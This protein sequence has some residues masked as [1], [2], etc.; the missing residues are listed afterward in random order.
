LVVGRKGDDGTMTNRLAGESSPYLLQHQD[1]PVDW[2]PWSEEA[3]AAAKERDKPILLSIG[4]AACHWCHVMERESFEDD[5]TA[6][7]MNEHFVSIKVD[8]EERP[9]IDSIYMEAV[10]ALTGHGGWPMTMFLTTDGRPFYGGTYYPPEGRY[11]MPSF[12]TVLLAIADAWQNRR[13]EVETQSSRL[14]EHIGSATR[15]QASADPISESVLDEATATLAASFDAEHGG[16]GGAPKF[17]QAMTLDFLLRMNVRGDEKAGAI[18]RKTLDEM[19]SGGMFDQLGGGFHRYSVDRYW[20]VPHFEKMLYDNALLLRTYARAY[21]VFTEPLYRDVAERT[22][23]WMLDE[24]R[25]EGGGFYASMDA[26][27]EGVEGKYYV[28][29]LD[30]VKEVTGSDFHAAEEAWGFTAAGNFEGANIPVRAAQVDENALERARTAL[31]SRRSARVPPATDTKVLTSWSSLA[32]SALAEAGVALDRPDWIEAAA[33]AVDF[34]LVKMRP[35]GRLMRSFRRIDGDRRVGQLGVCED[36]SCLL[37][38]CLALYEATHD[39]RWFR[40][41]RWAADETLRLFLDESSGG[42]YATGTDAE[43]L[44]MRPKDLFDNAVPAS[45]SILA[46]ELQRLSR[47]SGVEDYERHGLGA[48]RPV[49]PLIAESPQ[50]FGHLLQAI[51]FYTAP[52]IEVVIVGEPGSNDTLAL[53][54]VLGSRFIPNKVLAVGDDPDEMARDIPLFE[55]RKRLDGK[56]TAFVCEH[57]VCKLPVD[58]P[59][60]LERQ[61][62][63]R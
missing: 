48:V 46:L 4:Y 32:A 3:L 47:L 1:N 14:V 11:G 17:P 34:T 57:G 50:G 40:E 43:D 5:E 28:W 39:V 49:L 19:A 30:E 12:K 31:L 26:D 27:S 37:E 20:L 41:A 45:N 33:Q 2:Y 24:M 7:L 15:L 16:F 13:E 8:R 38:A 56:A 18:V 51:D 54:E 23:A 52:A 35:D 9:D 29:S 58:T 36:Y 63:R 22:A 53:I 61:L 25:D 44:V 42:F 62:E 6:A 10:Q 21:L 59:D 60:E 55:D